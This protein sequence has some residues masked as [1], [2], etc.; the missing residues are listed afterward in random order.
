MRMYAVIID[1]DGEGLATF[2]THAADEEDARARSRAWRDAF[3]TNIQ[4][5]PY[6]LAMVSGFELS[7]P[8]CRPTLSRMTRQAPK[9]C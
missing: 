7:K 2:T 8:S 6:T 9:P 3:F 5:M 1:Q 4:S